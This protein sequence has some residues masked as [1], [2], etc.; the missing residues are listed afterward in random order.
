MRI[1]TWSLALVCLCLWP[2][3]ASVQQPRAGNVVLVTLDGVR[4]QEVF[5]GM[6]ESL[7]RATEPKGT[8]VT[9]LPVY[10]EFSAPSA[11][12]RR[13]R[14]MPF[15]WKTLVAQH[16]FIVGDRT[17]GSTVS[18]TNR[19]RFSYPGYSEMLTGQAHDDVIKSNDAIRNQF[20]SVLQFLRRKLTLEPAQVA[21][22]ASWGVF[23]EIVESEPGATTINAGFEPFESPVPE[24]QAINS[25]Q[26]DI[27]TPWG[28]ARHDAFTFRFAMDYAKRV[29]PRVLYIAFDETD[30]W[31]HDGRYPLVLET[32]NR[33]DRYL[34]ELWEFLQ[35]DAQYQGTTT[36]IVTTDHGRGRTS[37][38]W[39]NHGKDVPGADEIWMAIASPDSQ[40][41]G[42]WHNHPPLFQNQI[43]A[44]MA[45]ALGFDYKEQN[46]RAGQAIALR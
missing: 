17:A 6:D 44:T 14:L 23:N 46:P 31:A 2:A 18:V 22:F 11:G 37:S 45:A 42:L 16:A 35:R 29:H 8:D 9:T 1:R 27:P 21:T 41:R 38:D 13:Q 10:R 28:N 25:L 30:D 32:L 24:I 19:H 15:L 5:G 34:K 36:L 3:T 39:K 12:D 40:R 20:P 33:T 7:L 26:M 43:A 4:W